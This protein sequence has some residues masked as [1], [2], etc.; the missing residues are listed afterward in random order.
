MKL[1]I[2]NKNYSSW[3]LRPW[4]V[5]Q[6]FAIPFEEEILLL[7]G[8]GWK[9]NLINRTPFGFVPVLIDGKLQIVE[10]IAIIE[11]LAD[12]NP[13]KPIW[14][15]NIRTRALARSAAAQMHAGFKKIRNA[16]P[17]NLRAF[18]PNR[19]IIDEIHSD[20]D[21]IEKL[22]GGHLAEYGGPFLFGEFCAA[23]AMFAP[24]ATRLKTYDLPMSDVVRAYVDA[25]YSLSAFQIWH[26]A[27]LKETAIVEMDEI[28]FIQ[29][30][31]KS[32]LPT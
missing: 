11:Y 32:G 5:L 29:S 10:T 19:V 23:D 9:E 31:E 7:N 17:M 20:L 24:L 12:T 2:A 22:W 13:Q 25:I 16:A 15:A 21:V 14:P 30:K 28:D 4:L 6:H 3:S 18:H 1:L 8:E 27:A 26:K